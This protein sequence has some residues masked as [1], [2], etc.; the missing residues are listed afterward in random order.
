[1]RSSAGS[2][3]CLLA[4]ALVL[5]ASRARADRVVV[6]P[7]RGG[8]ADEGG[9]R[10]ALDIE[11]TRALI[12][13]GHATVPETEAKAALA[14][15]ADGVADTNEEYRAVGQAVQADWVVVGTIE[16]AVVTQRVELAAALVSLG[17][18]ESVARDVEKAKSAIQVQEMVEVLLRPE[19]IGVG[20]LPWEAGAPTPEKPKAA[21]AGAPAPRPPEKPDLPSEPHRPGEKVHMEY[22]D[23]GE[24]VWPPYAA[25]NRAF[26]AVAQGFAVAAARQESASGTPWSIVAHARGGYALGDA[27]I[28]MFAQVG[29]NL[30][31]PRAL[32][33]DLGARWMF[34]PSLH[35]QGGG[36]GPY[37]ALSF[38]MGPELTLGAF[39]R[40]AGPD[41]EAPDG[42]VYE[43]TTSVHPAL[44][45]GLGM[46]LQMT[47]HI[48]IEGQI[49]N[50]RWVPTG[51]G[52]IILFGATLGAGL[53]F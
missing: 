8:T 28:E 36:S 49:G 34:T 3:G 5:T 2:L 53:R 45:L 15:V 11:L 17:R 44:G 20:A 40:L 7:S 6:L 38:H 18:V 39:M 51:E 14:T 4:A 19:G 9:A 23:H 46:A 30:V 42:T 1:M 21:V 52:S 10:T 22:F 41:V 13:L 26:V 35:R 12:A 47:P 50:F 27:G 16:A 32:W 48:Q 29:G 43:G 31:G 33:I 24:D 37:R 25:G